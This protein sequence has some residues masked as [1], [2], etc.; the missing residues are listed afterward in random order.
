MNEFFRSNFNISK[1]NLCMLVKSEAASPHHINR[2]DHGLVFMLSGK[3]K[4]TFA[5]KREIILEKGDIYYLPKFSNYEVAKTARGEVIAVNFEIDDPDK[6][7]PFFCFKATAPDN[8][9]DDFERLL[10]A[11][12]LNKSGYMNVCYMALYSIICRIQV[13]ASAVYL[14]S[15]HRKI[16]QKGAEFINANISDDSLGIEAVAAHLGITPEYFR[17]LFKKSYGIAPRKYIVEQRI[18]KAK[19]LLNSGELKIGNIAR[20]CGYSS[21]SYFSS[22]FKK[23]TAYT[24]T[25]Y[26]LLRNSL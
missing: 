8:Y 22:E 11:W 14:P 25:E 6:T 1:I 9:L 15:Y 3:T 18:S 10:K 21:V 23:A 5:E 12:N 13:E 17:M 4:V 16:S 20:L 19:E 26:M 2:R 7:F 24:P